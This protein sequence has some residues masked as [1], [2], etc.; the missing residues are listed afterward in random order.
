MNK[1]YV[2]IYT[3]VMLLLGGGWG[4]LMY[5]TMPQWW[6]P[7]YPIIPAF[8]YLVGLVEVYMLHKGETNHKKM[9][10]TMLIQRMVRWVAV[11][12]VLVLLLVLARPPKV[13]FLISFMIM[14]AVYSSMSIWFL[15]HITTSKN[16]PDNGNQ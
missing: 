8:F 2:L 14:F 1:K 3:L 7:Q 6:F 9:L 10:N 15:A 4:L 16:K 12:V 11:L 5:L 13:S